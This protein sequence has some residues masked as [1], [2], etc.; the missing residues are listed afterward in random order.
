MDKFQDALEGKTTTDEWTA[1][2][3][4]EYHKFVLGKV[5]EEE[6]KVGG[7]REA[8]RAETERIEKLKAEADKI[9]EDI[10]Q[11]KNTPPEGEEKPTNPEMTQF[12]SEQIEKAKNR[13]FSEMSFSEEEKKVILEK[14][15]R[16]DSGKLDSDFIYLDLVSALAAA[17]PEKFL[18]LKKKADEE[19]RIAQE[20]IER[21]ASG[22]GGNPPQE[23][24]KK[25][26]SDEVIALSKKAGITNE[27][28]QK[29]IDSGMSRTLE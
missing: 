15:E 27:A 18:T 17:N 13:L 10:Q 12:R 21:Q 2:E 23:G 19:E 7:L 3:L 22:E 5:K 28:A 20:E 26:F 24:E 8:K 4:V 6:G 29:Q 16:L 1:E 11:K 14:F 9:E 25:V